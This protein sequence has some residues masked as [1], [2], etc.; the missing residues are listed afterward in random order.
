M[1]GPLATGRLR[2]EPFVPGDGPLL[3]GLDADPEVVRY[4]HLGPFQPPGPERYEDEVLPRFLAGSGPG[5]GSWKVFP[6]GEPVP[7]GV[8]PGWV[9]LRPV[10]AAKW[11]EAVGEHAPADPALPELG[12]RFARAYWG[13]GYAT[14]AARAVLAHAAARGHRRVCALRQ[15]DNAGS[16]RVMAKLGLEPVR[17]FQLDG[18]PAPSVLS[19]GAIGPASAAAAA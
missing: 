14:E 3:A 5:C 6:K 7:A 4:V 15:E 13:R 10:G 9:F 11:Y 17:T 1:T 2:L 12:Y 8:L 19:V 18:I 16:A